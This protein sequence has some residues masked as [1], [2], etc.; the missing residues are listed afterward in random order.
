MPIRVVLADDHGVLRDSL[1]LLLEQE[2]ISVVG[3]AENGAEAVKLART[4]HPQVVVTDL[5]M[6]IMN[7]IE[8]AAEIRKELGIPTILLTMHAEEHYVLRAFQA[9]VVGYLLKSK[10]ASDLVT[11]LQ[12]VARGNVYLSP[13]I[14]RAVIHEMLNKDATAKTEILTLRERQALQLIAEGKTTKEVAQL[15]G[16]SV[17]TGESHRARIMEKLNIHETAGLV[18]YAIRQGLVQP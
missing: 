10:V 12:E 4:L 14:S 8:A 7:G 3:E 2:G 5:S 6:P 9:G 18:R 1:K 11:A 13:G 15:M 16:I 17:R